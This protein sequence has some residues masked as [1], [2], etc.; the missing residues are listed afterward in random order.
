VVNLQQLPSPGNAGNAGI[1]LVGGKGILYPLNEI[2][3]PVNG[4][5]WF[6]VEFGD[7]ITSYLM[8]SG[9]QSP[10]LFTG[11]GINSSA[12]F[13]RINTRLSTY[14]VHSSSSLVVVSLY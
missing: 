12:L 9:C 10:L 6:G 8:T 5:Y 3:Y 13:S 7:P 14:S 2:W 4:S 1:V 11:L